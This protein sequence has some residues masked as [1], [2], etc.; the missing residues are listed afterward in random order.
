MIFITFFGFI[1][2]AYAGTGTAN[3]INSLLIILILFLLISY[4]ASKVRS[5]IQNRLHSENKINE[6]IANGTEGNDD[7]NYF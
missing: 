7:L 2:F 6:N 3:D 1:K 4:L 5:Y